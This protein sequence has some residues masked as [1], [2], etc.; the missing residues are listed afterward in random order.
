MTAKQFIS[1]VN[2]ITGLVVASMAVGLIVRAE[3]VQILFS[4][5]V[6][7][8][9]GY[10]VLVMANLFSGLAM[11]TQPHKFSKYIPYLL[12]PAIFTLTLSLYL[13]L[14]IDDYTVWSASI[15]VGWIFLVLFCNWAVTYFLKETNTDATL[16]TNVSPPDAAITPAV[17]TGE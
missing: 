13:R 3:T 2:I 6:K 9:D 11:F 5:V 8:P 14:P 17:S 12:M 1:W 7:T 16:P 10:A 15:Y 4:S